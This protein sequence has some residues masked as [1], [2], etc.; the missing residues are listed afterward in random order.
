MKL[1]TLT[2]FSSYNTF[3]FIFYFKFDV[4]VRNFKHIRLKVKHVENIL[5][6]T[7]LVFSSETVPLIFC[8]KL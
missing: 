5:S 2:V 7:Q 6:L 3:I 8:Y 4:M 1:L